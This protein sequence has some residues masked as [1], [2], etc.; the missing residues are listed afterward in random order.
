MKLLLLLYLE[1]SGEIYFFC[2]F[3]AESD[4]G[5]VGCFPVGKTK[6]FLDSPLFISIVDRFWRQC[7]LYMISQQLLKARQTEKENPLLP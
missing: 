5:D 3:Q 6:S 7:L 1:W 2:L 4:E